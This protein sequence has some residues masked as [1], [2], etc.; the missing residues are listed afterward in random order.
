[1]FS[2]VLRYEFTG[3]GMGRIKF[4]FG[5]STRPRQVERNPGRGRMECALC[6]RST[7]NRVCI[8]HRHCMRCLQVTAQRVPCDTLWWS[9]GRRLSAW[10]TCLIPM[11]EF[12]A[13]FDLKI[14]EPR[15]WS[16]LLPA[17]R[18][19]APPKAASC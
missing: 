14:G 10:D 13:G 12:T 9:W 8:H 17:G 15:I 11:L 3:T 5:K 4:I 1:M 18:V 19:A 2:P 7:D 16:M 6:T